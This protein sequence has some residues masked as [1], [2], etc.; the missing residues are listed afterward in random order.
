[1]KTRLQE[2]T[3]R[4]KTRKS[5][6]DV[7]GAEELSSATRLGNWKKLLRGFPVRMKDT[8]TFVGER[9]DEMFVRGMQHL[10]LAQMKKMGD[11]EEGDI[12]QS[13]WDLGDKKRK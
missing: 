8:C 1:M 4:E 2:R 10:H 3:E 9:E 6:R 11:M 12:I 5:Y 13:R 7:E